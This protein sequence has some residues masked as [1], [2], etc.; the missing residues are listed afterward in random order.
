MAKRQPVTIMLLGGGA[1]VFTLVILI[2]SRRLDENPGHSKSKPTAPSS[3][4][5][6]PRIDIAINERPERAKTHKDSPKDEL[7]AETLKDSPTGDM[8]DDLDDDLF[9]DEPAAVRRAKLRPAELTLQNRRV[10][11]Q[12]VIEEMPHVNYKGKKSFKILTVNL[13]RWTTYQIDHISKD[14][15]AFLHLEDPDGKVVMENSSPRIGGLS[16]IVFKTTRAGVYRIIATSLAGYRT[17]AFSCSIRVFNALLSARWPNGMPSWLIDLD[18]DGDGQVGLDEWLSE[19]KSL[20]E[21]RKYDL[22]GDGFI[23]AEE[24]VRYIKQPVELWLQG[25]RAK[26]QGNIEEMPDATYKGKKSFKILTVR[27]EPGKTY[28]IEHISKDMQ[29]FLH[30]EGPGG[31]VVMENSSP[32][33]GGL[34]RIVYRAAQFGTYRIIATSLA[35]VRTGA[36]SCSVRVVSSALGGALP[37]QLPQWFQDLDPNGEDRVDLLEWRKAGMDL[38]EFRK[39]DLNHDG[40]ISVEELLRYLKKPVELK[41]KNGRA[42]YNG[43]LSESASGEYRGKM[44]FKVFSVQLEPGQVYQIDQTSKVFQPFLY[45]EDSAGNL[46]A[47]NRSRN[48]GGNSRIVFRAGQAGSYRIVATS[49]AGVRT[50]DFSLS[51]R[52]GR[53]LPEGLPS[54]FEDLDKDGDGQLSVR[55]W[56]EGRRKLDEFRQIDVNDDGTITADELLGYLKKPVDLQLK[57]GQTIFHGAVNESFDGE[58]RGKKSFKIL[59]IQLEQGQTYQIDHISKAFQAFLYLEDS[60]GNLRAENSS[61]SVGEN[62]RIVFHASQTGTYRI[63]ATSQ[64]GVRTGDFSLSVRLGHI[65]PKGLPS[66]FADLDNDG[67]GQISLQESKEGGMQLDDFRKID[68][69]DDGFI[70]PEELLRYLKPVRRKLPKGLPPWFEVLD[71]DGDGQISLHEWREGGAKLDDFRQYDLN[72]DGFITSEEVLRYLKK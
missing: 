32:S 49:Q 54:W 12:G 41:L 10:H 9:P 23:T 4:L 56:R 22:N 53:F 20:D 59:T 51:I 66:W 15:Q 70:T 18:T 29:A 48:V 38:D 55:E 21:F 57:N 60:A 13:E 35:G 45:L 5:H 39:Y 36:F 72:D 24:M 62:S 61:P 6:D 25:G 3:P 65:L 42:N 58:Y 1:L 8:D 67:D 52:L 31:E 19:R 44:S 30:L 2:T 43:A 16:R 68:L 50:G 11:Y 7:G 47:D 33:I 71:E 14:M 46:L 17:G 69:N 37:S 64:A 26:Y 27:L 28:L 34:S 40:T 63:I